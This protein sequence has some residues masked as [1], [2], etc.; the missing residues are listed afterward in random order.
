V[1]LSGNGLREEVLEGLRSTPRT[2]PPKLFY[3]ARG[4]ELFE[5]I[6]RLPE[7]YL[8]RTEVGIFR[9][10]LPEMA[11]KIG[12]EVVVVEFGSGSGEKTDLLLRALADPRAYVSIDVAREQLDRVA[13]RIDRDFPSLGVYPLPADY[14]R[15]FTLPPEAIRAGRPLIFFPG[16]TI[17][18]FHPAE[19]SDFLK[20]ARTSLG[21]DASLLI[22]IDLRKP[23]AIVEP[24]YNDAAGVTAEFNRNALRN[25]N[26][27]L[28]AD[29]EPEAFK[30]EAV[31]NDEAS[32]I[33]MWLVA[34]RPM[35]VRLPAGSD[36][37]GA[38]VFEF[39]EGDRIVTEYSY[40]FTLEGFDSL[41][42]EAGWERVE[43]WSDP[44]GWFAVQFLTTA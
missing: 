8:T 37:R 43:S 5:A 18:N 42:S 30:H 36:A 7:Y 27:L 3:D 25:L 29:F 24:A 6:T 10:H 35:T 26:R 20:N 41:T 11:R 9:T 17:G 19:G 4:A 31:W 39:R 33:E 34:G 22:G 44:E 21:Q 32:R 16:S 2:L 40:K 38:E 23:R 15:P 13:A 12:P 1:P 14:T 28:D